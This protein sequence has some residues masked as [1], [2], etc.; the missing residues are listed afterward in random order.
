MNYI[1]LLNNF[2]QNVIHLDG[3]K[4][5]YMIVYFSISD[6]CNRNNWNETAI[7]IEISLAK[8]MVSRKTFYEA[9]KWLSL[10]NLIQYKAGRNVYSMAK[11]K[12]IEVKK[13]TST[14]TSIDTSDYTSTHTTTTPLPILNNKQENK[15]TI[16]QETKDSFE[17][18]WNLYDKKVGDKN[19]LLKKWDSL[20]ETDRLKIME[21]IP[22]YKISQ[23][24]KKFR[25][26]PSTFFNNKSW[27]DEIISS[28]LIKPYGDRPVDPSTG[29]AFPNF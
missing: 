1:Y 14:N 13:C 28:V 25:K 8:T 16:K 7:S 12:V 15:E 21:Y 29:K 22:K 6:S 18:F 23:P 27:N 10:N 3:Y 20:T 17:F 9:I 5:N 4:P 2:W 11:F 19:K 26:D 24:D